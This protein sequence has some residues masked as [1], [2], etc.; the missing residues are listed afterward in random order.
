MDRIMRIGVHGPSHLIDDTSAAQSRQVSIT[1][2][3]MALSRPRRD[4]TQHVAR[5][6]LLVRHTQLCNV[7]QSIQSELAPLNNMG[8]IGI[9]KQ[10]YREYSSKSRSRLP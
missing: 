1:T 3:C 10:A 8:M 4:T 6:S 2:R 5:D 9:A 7:S